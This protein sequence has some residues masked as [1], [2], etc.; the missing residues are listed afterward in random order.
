MGAGNHNA[1]GP[2]RGLMEAR[3]GIEP[4]YK[5]FAD[6]SLTTWV[7]RPS[8]TVYRKFRG[9]SA[10]KMAGL[11]GLGIVLCS[12]SGQEERDPSQES[13]R[14]SDL[15]RLCEAPDRL[16]GGWVAGGGSSCGRS[17]RTPRE[18][19]K[20]CRS[21]RC[22][23]GRESVAPQKLGRASGCDLADCCVLPAA[24]GE[25]GPFGPMNRAIALRRKARPERLAQSVVRG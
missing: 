1:N 13:R 10:W 16:G 25:E 22:T 9:D 21:D 12:R 14:R 18:L 23:F 8:Q 17:H 6:L 4:T 20:L 24:K 5:G 3:V 15:W 11:S 7:P 2:D 19:R